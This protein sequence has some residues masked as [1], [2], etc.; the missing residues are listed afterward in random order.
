MRITKEYNAKLQSC[1]NLQDLMDGSAC[2]RAVMMK[3][4]CE[5]YAECHYD[6]KKVYLTTERMV[7]VE[8]KDR[9]AEWRGL[10]RMQCLMK[11]FS[12]GKVSA[13]EVEACKKKSHDV[14]HLVI[15]YPKMP[16]LEVCKVP[17]RY[18]TTAQYKLAEFA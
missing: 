10:K 1:D 11:S 17:D 13:S 15:K 2:K 3:D 8:E 7:K 4:A 18:P 9:Q 16:S 12:D 5:T 6:K 14:G